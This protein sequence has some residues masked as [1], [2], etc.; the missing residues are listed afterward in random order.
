MDKIEIGDKVRIKDRSDW[1]SPP[2]YRFADAEGTVVQWFLWE[3]PM[4]E[5]QDYVFIKLE[6]TKGDAE[7]YLGNTMPFEVKNLE[8]I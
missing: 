4:A 3:E 2:G 8:K 7:A 1:P 6:K 5:F